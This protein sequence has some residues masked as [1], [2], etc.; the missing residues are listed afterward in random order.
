MTNNAIVQVPYDDFSELVNSQQ[1]QEQYIE[2]LDFYLDK[3]NLML[4]ETKGMGDIMQVRGSIEE[5]QSLLSDCLSGKL[6]A[7]LHGIT[8]NQTIAL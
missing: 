3:M 6:F 8:E 2:R 7:P 5:V 1:G 4:E